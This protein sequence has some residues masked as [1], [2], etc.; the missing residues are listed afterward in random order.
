MV[1]E[2]DIDEDEF[3]DK[4]PYT[5]DKK[6]EEPEKPMTPSLPQPQVPAV[7]E[8]VEADAAKQRH[9]ALLKKH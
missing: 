5:L 4:W 6:V 8:K 1:V 3:E 9:D 2:D 7:D